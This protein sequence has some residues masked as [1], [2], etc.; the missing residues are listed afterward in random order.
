MK[1]LIVHHHPQ[2]AAQIMELQY[3]TSVLN[4]T[5][6][7]TG[8]SRVTVPYCLHIPQ[9][10]PTKSVNPNRNPGIK[11]ASKYTSLAKTLVSD[12]S[13][14]YDV[15][16]YEPERLDE[17]VRKHIL[18]VFVA[19]ESG[20][21]NRVAGVFARRGAN[22]ESLAVGLTKDKALF[23][24]VATGTDATVANLTKQLA[25]LV[26]VRYVEDITD[27]KYIRTFFQL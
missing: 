18:S 23:T 13:E 4:C 5:R 24:I 3:H 8:F 1:I 10:R 19:D 21:I 14:G 25:K 27:Q 17:G 16:V 9:G 6:S 12:K 11:N 20:L 22:I 15:Y 7:Y 26:N 2:R